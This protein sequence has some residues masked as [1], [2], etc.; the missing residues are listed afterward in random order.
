MDR[1]DRKRCVAAA[2]LACVTALGGC[3]TSQSARAKLVQAPSNCVDQSVQVYFEPWSAELTREGQ[4]VI[5]NAAANVRGCRLGGVQVT[6][7]ADSVGAPGPNLE[8]S[9]RRA[10]SVTHALA[11]AGLPPA[12]F[13]V[14][15][16]GQTG[17]VTADG[18]SAPLRRRVDVNLR[19]QR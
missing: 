10:Q 4:T 18:A 19:V 13:S 11:A 17:A 1:Y 6:G 9:Q 14:D 7:L 15:A 2:A 3:T 16:A 8:L 12:E 5:D